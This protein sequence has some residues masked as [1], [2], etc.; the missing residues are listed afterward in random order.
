[1]KNII[2]LLFNRA[3]VR[4]LGPSQHVANRAG[5]TKDSVPVFVKVCQRKLF[6]ACLQ[7]KE[8]SILHVVNFINIV[9]TC[10]Y[11]RTNAKTKY[12]HFNPEGPLNSLS[13]SSV[14]DNTISSP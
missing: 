9:K 8:D 5:F 2:I 10:T 3:T 11:T 14:P 13:S 4:Y 6:D 1:M 12:K 7:R